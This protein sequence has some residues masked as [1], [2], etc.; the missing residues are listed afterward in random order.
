M[1]LV[2]LGTQDKDFKRL[3][4][5]IDKEIENKNINEEVIVQAG[6]T[7]YHSNNMKI[8]DFISPK[9]LDDLMKSA[10]IIITH[11]G[12]GS[13]LGALKYNKPIIAAARLSKYKEHTNDHQ[14]EIL[15]EFEKEGHILALKD[16]NKLDNLLMKANSFK[17]NKY[18][19][20]N[21]KFTEMIEEN[22]NKLSKKSIW[23]RISPYVYL[24]ILILII[25]LI[26]M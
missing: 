24:I 11:A 13:I 26:I 10:R 2:T 8:F 6:Y 21:K 12:V 25:M 17:P 5:A 7:K 1:I 3:L 18:K 20:N 23:Y 16:F 22:I 15:N 9:E 4:K 19:S 14:K